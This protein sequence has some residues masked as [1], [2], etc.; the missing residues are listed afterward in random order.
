MS[1]RDLK[2]EREGAEEKGR[3]SM[4][5]RVCIRIECAWSEWKSN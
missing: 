3:V 5:A 4:R 2:R 1:S